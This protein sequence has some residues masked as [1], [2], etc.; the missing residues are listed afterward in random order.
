MRGGDE[1]MRGGDRGEGTD[2]LLCTTNDSI[3]AKWGSEVGNEIESILVMMY[4]YM[5]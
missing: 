3:H 5:S 4:V 2:R 1:G